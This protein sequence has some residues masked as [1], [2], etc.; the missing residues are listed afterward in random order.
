V[1]AIHFTPKL[2]ELDHADFGGHIKS[3]VR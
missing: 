1:S 2:Y 3:H